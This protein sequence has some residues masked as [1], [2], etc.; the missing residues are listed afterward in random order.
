MLAFFWQAMKPYK[1][2]YLLVFQGPIVSSFYL[3]IYSY[4]LKKI[5]DL[6][7][8]LEQFSWNAY[9]LPVGLFIFSSIF[10]N[11]SLKLTMIGFRNVYPFTLT[12]II[13]STFEHIQNQSYS[14]FQNM[15]SGL[16][17]SKTKGLA[18]QFLAVFMSFYHQLSNGL[19]Y[20]LVAW[21]MLWY[22]N[23]MLGI[24]MWLW[25]LVFSLIMVSL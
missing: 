19:C 10:Q 14:Y 2:W 15:P 9:A 4:A 11:T 21:I 8:N 17:V 25:G 12:K 20:T 7:V 23:P 22:I 13:T 6:I 16:L 24:F 18:D 1:W 5:I 3:V